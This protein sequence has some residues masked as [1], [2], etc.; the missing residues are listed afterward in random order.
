MNLSREQLVRLARILP[1]I[2]TGMVTDVH[3]ETRTY[4]VQTTDGGSVTGKPCM[5]D[6]G[7]LI[8]GN[9]SGTLLDVGAQVLYY[10]DANTG[11]ILG[12]VSAPGIPSTPMPPITYSNVTSASEATEGPE[13]SYRGGSPP[14]L[15]PGDWLKYNPEGGFLALLRGA[16]ATIGTSPMASLEFN[17]ID[18]AGVLNARNLFVNT[19][20]MEL[21]SNNDEG[22][23][24]LQIFAAPNF[25]ETLGA[26][27]PGKEL[28][29]HAEGGRKLR[30]TT[31]P[32]DRMGKWRIHAFAGWLGDN[33]HLFI[34]RRGDA[35]RRSDESPPAG[36]TEIVLSHD[37]A[38]RV[39][40]CRELVLEKVARIHVPKKMRE[41]YHNTHGDSKE[42]GNYDPS[43]HQVYVW[44]KDHPEGRRM[45]E[46]GY[47][48]HTVD[49]EE[50]RHF[51]DHKNDWNVTSEKSAPI[52]DSKEGGGSFDSAEGSNVDKFEETYSVIHQRSDG[53]IYL[54]DNWGSV[55]DMN[56]ED[57]SFSAKRDLK[58]QAG[59]DVLITGAREGAIRTQED[60]NIVSHNGSLR[61]KANNDLR[62][63]A[64]GNASL[65]SNRGNTVMLS[66]QGNTLIRSE[67]QDVVIKSDL[68]NIQTVAV[69]GNM[70]FRASSNITILSDSSSVDVHGSEAVQ[71]SSQGT[72]T[73][74]SGPE[75]SSPSMESSQRN[76][77]TFTD[78]SNTL[79][80]GNEA[81]VDSLAF[82]EIS[83]SGATLF[84]QGNVEVASE[85]TVNAFVPGS[86]VKLSTGNAT[87]SS[88]GTVTISKLGGLQLNQQDDGAGSDGPD[89]IWT[90]GAPHSDVGQPTPPS[91]SLTSVEATV[92]ANNFAD[93]RF[94]YSDE[95][96]EDHVVYQYPWQNMDPEAPT[97]G[98]T[99]WKDLINPNNDQDVPDIGPNR[100]V[101]DDR[102]EGE[103]TVAGSE[104]RMLPYGKYF[105]YN[106][107]TFDWNSKEGVKPGSFTKTED[108]LVPDTSATTTTED[109]VG[110]VNKIPASA[111]GKSFTGSTELVDSEN[112]TSQPL[113]EV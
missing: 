52:P 33:L 14:D 67:R 54:E 106:Y 77:G 66:R 91:P 18:D 80:N 78:T 96:K 86:A 13:L 32:A 35:N 107:D 98:L 74:A 22:E 71:V 30:Y 75:S 72:V 9:L 97:S 26:D 109:A 5:D 102:Q 7:G 21:E 105:S 64:E 17:S 20:F 31:E 87:L 16:L 28:G 55:V 108:F 57:I 110:R 62:L 29:V 58:L 38:V 73:V 92:Q 89:N 45:Q 24:N 50:I 93:G 113:R 2:K 59:R 11:V 1:T 3:P 81:G 70:D 37:G 19:D 99:P 88:R 100:P 44:D 85:N 65:D 56:K 46:T 36:L 60:L 90:P 42:K 94:R 40:S 112:P 95:I 53:S 82:L 39:R 61:V 27:E 68:G 34:S 6:T 12:A 101:K 84:G 103:G 47:H 83:G 41:A 4:T 104:E 51:R 15:L 23:T 49:H 8:R 48:N 43:E 10:H 111:E 69:T 79:D 25:F 63:Y 76:S